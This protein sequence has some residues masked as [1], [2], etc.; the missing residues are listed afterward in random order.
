MVVTWGGR[1]RNLLF[2]VYSFRFVRGKSSK[3]QFYNN[4]NILNTIEHLKWLKQCL[5]IFKWLKW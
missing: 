3:D 2:N 1:K 4:V 5:Y